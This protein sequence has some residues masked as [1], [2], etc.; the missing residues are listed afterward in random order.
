M[1]ETHVGRLEQLGTGKERL[2]GLLRRERLRLVQQVRDFGQDEPAF[3]RVDRSLVEC[4]RFL[5]HRA[6]VKMVE[7]SGIACCRRGAQGRRVNVCAPPF[8]PTVP[9]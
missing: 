2:R 1:N 8:C 3:P 5:Q 6:L 7:E 4:P 9:R